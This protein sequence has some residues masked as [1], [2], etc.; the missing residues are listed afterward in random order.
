MPVVW[1]ARGR[2]RGKAPARRHEVE[3]LRGGQEL[4]LEVLSPSNAREAVRSHLQRLDPRLVFLHVAGGARQGEPLEWTRG[5]A[6]A[7]GRR[8]RRRG[9]G[10]VRR[11]RPTVAGT[12][13][14]LGGMV[15]MVASAAEVVRMVPVLAEAV[16]GGCQEIFQILI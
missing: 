2:E 7:S 4:A 5:R 15:G 12:R 11:G 3:C 1:G 13:R 16:C 14:A 9:R 8:R 10:R 6:A